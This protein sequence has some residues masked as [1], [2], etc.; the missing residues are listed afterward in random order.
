MSNY[1]WNKRT[2]KENF[3]RDL[4]KLREIAYKHAL[5]Y[6]FIDQNKDT[7][8]ETDGRKKRSK[9]FQAVVKFYRKQRLSLRYYQ[10]ASKTYYAWKYLGLSP[11]Q[12]GKIYQSILEQ[13]IKQIKSLNLNLSL[14]GDEIDWNSL[15]IPTPKSEHLRSKGKEYHQNAAVIIEP[16]AA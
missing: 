3:K 15:V 13:K 10:A 6:E 14:T 4:S 11:V 8:F 5:Y 1:D 12:G 2:K 9:R 7:Y 16:Q